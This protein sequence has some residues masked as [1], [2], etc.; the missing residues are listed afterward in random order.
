MQK[1]ARGFREPEVFGFRVFYSGR[2]ESGVIPLKTCD[3]IAT[4]ICITAPIVDDTAY[5]SV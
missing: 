2:L 5:K 4:R 1:R 3:A